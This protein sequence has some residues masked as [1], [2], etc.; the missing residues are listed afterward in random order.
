[1]KRNGDGKPNPEEIDIAGTLANWRNPGARFH[2][3]GFDPVGGKRVREFAGIAPREAKDAWTRKSKVLAREI[4]QDD[5]SWRFRSSSG[6]L[7]AKRM[8]F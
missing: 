3:D 1:V 6:F 4:E 2:L 5:P 7:R 8:R